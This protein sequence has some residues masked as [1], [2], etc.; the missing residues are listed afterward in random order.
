MNNISKELSEIEAR[1][2]SGFL[3]KAKISSLSEFEGTNMKEF[4]DNVRQKQA[5]IEKLY[6]VKTQ[7][8]QLGIN[9]CLKSLE[10]LQAEEEEVKK[11]LAEV[12]ASLAE[13]EGK[14][15]S[16]VSEKSEFDKTYVDFQ[17]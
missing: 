16:K 5:L 14:Q 8:D 4:E 13:L 7:I 9:Q 3:K 10:V 6:Q 17:K 12:E 1:E 2:F 15:N 11:N